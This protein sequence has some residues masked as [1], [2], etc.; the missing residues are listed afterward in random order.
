MSSA[1]GSSAPMID[2]ILKGM[3]EADA[4]TYLLEDPKWDVAFVD[5]PIK[6]GEVSYTWSGGWPESSTSNAPTVT[7]ACAPTNEAEK[8]RSRLHAADQG[9]PSDQVAQL[10]VGDKLD[11]Q[12]FRRLED[13]RLAVEFVDHETLVVVVVAADA[14]ASG[15]MSFAAGGRDSLIDGWLRRVLR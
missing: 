3:R 9:T 12:V 2:R 14:P 8:L 4:R 11:I 15:R 1:G 5:F 7:I 6:P 13:G 10:R